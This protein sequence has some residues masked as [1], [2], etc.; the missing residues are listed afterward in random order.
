MTN[1][2]WCCEPLIMR[3][4]LLVCLNTQRIPVIVLKIIAVSLLG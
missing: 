2:T 3:I 1:C 4:Q